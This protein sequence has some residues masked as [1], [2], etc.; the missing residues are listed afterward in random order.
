MDA[1]CSLKGARVCQQVPAVPKALQ[2][3]LQDDGTILAW[4]QL[5]LLKCIPRWFTWRCEPLLGGCRWEQTAV[6]CRTSASPI[7]GSPRRGGS[8]HGAEAPVRQAGAAPSSVPTA[9]RGAEQPE[10]RNPAWPQTAAVP[11]ADTEEKPPHRL[12]RPGLHQQKIWQKFGSSSIKCPLCLLS[13]RPEWVLLSPILFCKRGHETPGEESQ[14]ETG[15]AA[16]M[17]SLSGASANSPLSFPLLTTSHTWTILRGGG[18]PTG[19]LPHALCSCSRE[20]PP[21]F[22]KCF[23]STSARC[24]CEFPPSVLWPAWD[25]SP[26]PRSALMSWVGFK[27]LKSRFLAPRGLAFC[28]HGCR[29]RSQER[30]TWLSARRAPWMPGRAWAPHPHPSCC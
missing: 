13:C 26:F 14:P 3:T 2:Q 22:P 27:C 5:P 25:C 20:R 29:K 28:Q 6:G 8:G 21:W 9:V 18:L 24:R 10:P 19:D 12:Y 11:S 4:M 7:H 1:Q 23:L 15:A 17:S 30:V 16:T